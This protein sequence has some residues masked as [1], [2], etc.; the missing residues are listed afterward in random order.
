MTASRI[1][2]VDDEPDLELLVTQRFRKEIRGGE[3]DFL[4]AHDGEEALDVLRAEPGI[5]L[6]LSD[7]NMPRM[8]GL[9]LLERLRAL[10]GLFKVVMVSA[11][12]DMRNIRLAMN[13]GAFDFVTKPIEFDDLKVTIGKTLG[14]LALLR[15][16]REKTAAAEEAR[17][18]IRDTFGKYV[19]EAVAKA[20]IEDRGVLK[21]EQRTATI[22]FTDIAQFT[23]IAQSMEPADLLNM[24][25]AY[26]G[27]TTE[28]ITKHHGVINQFQGDAIL[29]TFNVPL[30]DPDHGA[31]ALRAA[32]EIQD[33]G[34]NRTFEGVS[35]ET[36]IG[37]NTGRVIAGS[38]GG[39]GRLHYTVHG[40][41]V[42]LAARLEQLNKEHGTSILVSDTTKDA[43]GGGFEFQKMGTAPIRGRSTTVELFT[44]TG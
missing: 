19:P 16:S 44:L 23:S 37:I 6:V 35:L 22:L 11:Y 21:P 42:N 3:L 14:E 38:V 7:I 12:G 13:R 2:V 29:A 32:L 4:F 25:N 43:A 26:F 17:D 1:L 5:D 9:T 30:E 24:L 15:E 31:N 39:Q 10:D 8:D 34:R 33:I 41:A 40:D 18:F 27:A 20:I 36:R 28:V